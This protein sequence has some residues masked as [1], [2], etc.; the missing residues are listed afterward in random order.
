MKAVGKAVFVVALGGAA[1]VAQ[2]RQESSPVARIGGQAI[3]E[4][5]LVPL[6]AG[7]LFQLKS[8]EYEVKLK[9]LQLLLNRRALEAAAAKN[10]LSTEAFLEQ[11]VDA[12]VLRPN[13]AEVDAFY[14]AQKDRISRPLGEVRPQLEQALWQAKRQQARQ[15]F[16]AQLQKESSVEIL[17]QRPALEITADPGRVRGNPRAPVTILEF[18]DFQCPFCREVQGT[19]KTILDKYGD[20]VRLAFRDFPLNQIHPQAQ[21]AAEAGRCAGEQG[22]FWE[23]HDLLYENQR[24]LDLGGLK[25]L[26]QTAGLDANRFSSC[27][28]SGQYRP[29]IESDLQMGNGAGVNGTPGFFINGVPLAGAQPVAAFEQIIDSQLAAAQPAKP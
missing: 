4:D 24:R 18:G 17:L 28:A 10:G 29:S 13:N 15:E 5:E 8:Q 20:K 16:I 22:K 3:G 26:A 2:S 12:K 6:I 11:N 27:M 21:Q 14:L 7:Q 25:D 9:A 19:L 1:L 23:Y